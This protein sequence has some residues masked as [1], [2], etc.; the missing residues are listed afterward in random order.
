MHNRER[1]QTLNKRQHLYLFHTNKVPSILVLVDMKAEFERE[2]EFHK[3]NFCQATNASTLTP[4]KDLQNF[5]VFL[6]SQNTRRWTNHYSLLLHGW[7]HLELV[8]VDVSQWPH[9]L[10]Q[11]VTES[12]DPLSS[13]LLRRSQLRFV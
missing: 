2:R 7:I 5:T 11:I 6:L 10:V 12:W 1:S 8:P 3:L 4:W 13:Q 9:P